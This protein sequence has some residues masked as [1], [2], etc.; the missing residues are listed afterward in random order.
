[1]SVFESFKCFGTILAA[2]VLV[3]LCATGTYSVLL[4]FD[5]SAYAGVGIARKTK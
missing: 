3:S 4:G 2:G 1:M 5:L